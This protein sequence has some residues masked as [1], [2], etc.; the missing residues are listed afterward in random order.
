MKKIKGMIL[1]MFLVLCSFAIAAPSVD[2]EVNGVGV[3]AGDTVYLERG[4]EVEVEVVFE[5]DINLDDAR[6]KAWIGGYE[7][8]DVEDKS[9]IKDI[10]A[11]L[12]DKEV[13][14]FELPDDMDASEIYTLN[15]EIY[16]KVYSYGYT[17]SVKIEE[18]RHKLQILDVLFRP[19]NKVKAGSAF[20]GN[21]RVENLGDKKEED[22]KVIMS[23][24]DLGISQ[25]TY[26]DELTAHEID[27]E[28]EE[29]SASSD[30]IYLKIPENA[31]SGIYEVK[32]DVFYNKGHDKVTEK[33]TV[34]IVGALGSALAEKTLVSVSSD[35]QDIAEGGQ[36]SYK[37]SI[38]NMDDETHAYA[39][40]VEGEK[41][42]GS[43]S[44]EPALV[45]VAKD[46]TGDV[47]VNVKVD[48]GAEEGKHMFTVKVMSDNLMVA[49]KN[50]YANV[51]EDSKYDGLKKALVIGF[52]VLIVLLVILG[53]IIAFN[54]MREDDDEE[55]GEIPTSEGQAY[56]YKY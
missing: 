22:I 8:E 10:Q 43:S 29:D 14:S 19:T 37:L 9:D 26:I 47:L 33:S 11:G 13:L 50:F 56:Y 23:I 17:Y 27:N 20:F 6:V 42:W 24:P 2:V 51:V 34:E 40:Q 41:L 36:A 21:V 44:V 55:P 49:E 30:D 31:M 46:S 28:D 15:V 54:K 18:S 1:A 53:L 3:D 35:S 4:D 52:S 12:K 25:V 16:N 32:I 39:I 45:S 38:A 7:Y 48:E 5:S